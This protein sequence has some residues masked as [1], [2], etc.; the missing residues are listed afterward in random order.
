VS[1]EIVLSLLREE[2]LSPLGR[3]AA[4]RGARARSPALGRQPLRRS[5]TWV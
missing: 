4:R 3:V 2:A 5:A 1:R